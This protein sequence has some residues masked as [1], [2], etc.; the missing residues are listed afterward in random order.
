MRILVIGANGFIGS[1][2]FNLIKEKHDVTGTSTHDRNFKILDIAELNKTSKFLHKINPDTIYLP[3]GI[4]NLDYI[5]NHPEETA[6]ANVLGVR[7]IAGYCKEN[8]C[9]LVFFS[10]DSVFDGRKGPYSENDEPNPINIYG[11]QKRKGAGAS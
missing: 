8:N 4:T 7:N 11:K 10:S 9:K 2:L 1:Y 5:E 3:A 6:R